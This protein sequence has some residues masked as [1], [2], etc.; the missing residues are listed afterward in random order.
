MTVVDHLVPK[1]VLDSRLCQLFRR[2]EDKVVKNPDEAAIN[3]ANL[4][5]QSNMDEAC[6]ATNLQSASEMQRFLAK[7]SSGEPGEE[8]GVF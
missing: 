3:S 5:L 4:R 2:L 6:G 8:A 1:N 7:G